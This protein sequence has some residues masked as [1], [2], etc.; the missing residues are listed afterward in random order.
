VA[1]S[2]A[3]FDAW[4]S[5]RSSAGSERQ[6]GGVTCRAPSLPQEG[7]P[8]CALRSPTDRGSSGASGLSWSAAR[9]TWPLPTTSRRRPSPSRRLRW[10]STGRRRLRAPASDSGSHRAGRD[11]ARATTPVVRLPTYR[12]TARPSPVRTQRTPVHGHRTLR[13]G[14]W[15][16]GQPDAHTGHWTLD[17][18]PDAG[19]PRADIAHLDT[20]RSHRTLDAGRAERRGRGQGDQARPAPGHPGLPPPSGGPPG[21]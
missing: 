13:T 1:G 19:H 20:G 10:S 18:A 7:E 11:T 8:C 4:E 14:H 16:P 17:A 2:D 9:S 21:R 12:R 15:T 5:A 3:Q 6:G